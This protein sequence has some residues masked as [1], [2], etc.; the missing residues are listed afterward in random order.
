LLFIEVAVA[1]G[2]FLTYFEI[3][4][5]TGTIGVSFGTEFITGILLIFAVP[6]VV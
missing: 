6:T 4:I 1:I 3:G 5:T 2:R